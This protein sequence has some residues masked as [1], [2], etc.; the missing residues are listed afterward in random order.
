MNT[1]SISKASIIGR[2]LLKTRSGETAHAKEEST[3]RSN[4]SDQ[5]RLKM[6][7]GSDGVAIRILSRIAPSD[8]DKENIQRMFA[9]P[10]TK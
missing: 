4:I 9:L 3:F 7:D 10:E 2:A 6:G 8:D 1:G 5:G